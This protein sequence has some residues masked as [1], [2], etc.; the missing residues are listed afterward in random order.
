MRERDYIYYGMGEESLKRYIKV[1]DVTGWKFKWD[2]LAICTRIRIYLRTKRKIYY[3]YNSRNELKSLVFS[4]ISRKFQISR[5]RNI[6]H[7][8]FNF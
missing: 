4:S 3:Y 6:S 7:T 2:V 1:V 5:Y 8:P